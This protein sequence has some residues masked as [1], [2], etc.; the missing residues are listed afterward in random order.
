MKASGKRMRSN[1]A[2][3]SLRFECFL[4]TPDQPVLPEHP[5]W[6]RPLPTSRHAFTA[7]ASPHADAETA[8]PLGDYFQAIQAF[9]T[10][11]GGKAI[12][13][14]LVGK[15]VDP[16][17]AQVFRIFLVKHGEYYHPARVE[18]EIDGVPFP[19]VVNVAVSAA[20]KALVFK[21]Y[22]LLKRLARESTVAYI[23]RVYAAAE[24]DAGHGHSLA[25]FLGQWLA[26]FHEF[27]ATRGTPG[28]DQALALWDPA[29]D[30]ILLDDAQARA[31]YCQV[32]RILTD[33][34]NLAAF[35]VIGAW[36]HAAGDF[37]VRLEG[38]QAEV[39]LITVRDYRPL[40]RRRPESGDRVRAIK[41][42]LEALLIFLLNVSVRTRL[43]RLDGTGDLVWSDPLAV[44][45]TVAGV[46]DGLADKTVPWEPTLPIDALFSRYLAACPA[47]DILF[48]C[49]DLVEKNYPSGSAERCLVEAHVKEHTAALAEAFGRL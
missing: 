13:R 12:V 23:P 35:E 32:A 15:G 34:L 47:E 49:T 26:G 6:R 36:H 40:F 4:E 9:I 21:E 2:K 16:A 46:L 33:Y 20:G 48:L 17:A 10:E 8:I 25:M 42:L 19:W 18:T 29:S 43:D 38:R 27:H 14:A 37:V 11:T 22:A 45:A 24:V 41:G 44:E 28:G 3:T 30:P 39:R 5:L 1:G 31:V 7:P